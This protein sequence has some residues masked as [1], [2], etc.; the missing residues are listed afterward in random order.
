MESFSS[1]LNRKKNQIQLVK[2][3]RNLVGGLRT[4]GINGQRLLNFPNNH[5]RRQLLHM[6]KFQMNHQPWNGIKCLQTMG[7]LVVIKSFGVGMVNK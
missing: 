5:V 4:F 1:E 2:H 6:S 7:A 3:E